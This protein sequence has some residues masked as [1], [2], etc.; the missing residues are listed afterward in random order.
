[1]T[2]PVIEIN[3][4]SFAYNGNE[5]LKNV[6]LTVD[7]GEFLALI[8]P[9]GG[10]KTTLL[11]LMLGLLEPKRGTVRVF[12]RPPRTISHRI[13]Y[14]PQD[15]HFNRNF[16]ASALDVVLMGK[17]Q[18][19]KGWSRHSRQDRITA[20]AALDKM[21]VGTLTNRRIDE[22]SGGQRQRILIA[23]ALVSEPEL[24][25]MDEP[26]ASIDAQG[27]T[28]FYNRI[29]D[30]NKST[31]ILMVSH[32]L[33]ILSSYV[34]SVACVN[35]LVHHHDEAEITEDMLSMYECPVELIAHGLPHRVLKNH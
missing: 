25:F 8:G 7:D 9:N 16:P 14:V 34:K 6:N 13:G 32:D 1:M 3:D 28:E 35:Q 12:G 17:M 18:F 2:A 24:L 15:I 11:K 23:R 20:Q 31:T 33:M 19:R 21:E 10:G 29:K 4:L 30:L 26:T 27:Q 22:L 5:V